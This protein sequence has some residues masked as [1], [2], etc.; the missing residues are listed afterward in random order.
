MTGEQMTVELLQ[1]IDA[2]LR[3]L[4]TLLSATAPKP[5]ADDRDLDSKYG[6][7]EV[8]FVPRDWTGADYKGRHFSECPAEL[9]DLIANALDYLADKSEAAGE[10]YNGKPVAAYKRRDAARARGW[11]KRAREG[12]TR[13]ASPATAAPSAWADAGGFEKDDE[14][15]F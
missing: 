1:S 3:R 7:P 4:V 9:L 13:P 8:K 15:P 6:D 5:T 11:A 12:R 2:S 14:V 10:T